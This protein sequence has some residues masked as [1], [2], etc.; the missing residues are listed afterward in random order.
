[1]QRPMK[2]WAALK[3][4]GDGTLKRLFAPT[5]FGEVV[6]YLE[7]RSRD[8]DMGYETPCRIWVG[9]IKRGA[10]GGHGMIRFEGRSQI[11]SRLAWRASNGDVPDAIEV[12]H[13]CDVPAR[14]RL[15]HLFLGT[16]LQ[17]MLD[18]AKKQ[19][20]GGP[21]G[22]KHYCAKF[23]V[24]EVLA[25]RERFNNGEPPSRKLAAQLGVAYN[26]LRKIHNR[27]SWKHV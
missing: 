6:D 11:V 15:D 9:S 13:H 19:R 7:Q 25:L 26:A 18:A 20:M 2:K 12:C 22:E 16:H 3:L 10:R 27:E 1:M 5:T 14:I 4:C 17:N 8:Q 24:A 23:T 21:I